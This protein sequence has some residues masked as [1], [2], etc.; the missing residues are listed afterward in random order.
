MSLEESWAF[1][2]KKVALC[3]GPIS[4]DVTKYMLSAYIHHI[5]EIKPF[6]KLPSSLVFTCGLA[7]FI[8]SVFF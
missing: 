2:S 8:C 5:C 4:Y 6:L 1:Y 7:A 3:T